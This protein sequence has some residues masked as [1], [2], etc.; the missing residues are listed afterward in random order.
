[1]LTH[2]QQSSSVVLDSRSLKPIGT[3]RFAHRNAERHQAGPVE[4]DQTPRNTVPGDSP[5]GQPAHP[6]LKPKALVI[7]MLSVL[8]VVIL[9]AAVVAAIWSLPAGA[10]VLVFGSGL[11]FLGN[12]VIWATTQRKNERKDD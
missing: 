1:M 10:L 8:A 12:P 4:H 11:L 6:E 3:M 7:L 9:A 5:D 2:H